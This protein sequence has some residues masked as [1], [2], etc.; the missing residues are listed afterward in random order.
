MIFIVHKYE[1]NSVNSCCLFTLS[2][3]EF[4]MGGS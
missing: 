1:V 3:S 2:V 4:S